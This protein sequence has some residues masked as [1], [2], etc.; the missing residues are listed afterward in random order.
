VNAYSNT[1]RREERRVGKMEKRRSEGG[2]KNKT[3]SRVGGRV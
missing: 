1:R 3:G 2:L